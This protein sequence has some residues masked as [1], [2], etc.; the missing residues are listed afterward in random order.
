ML[1]LPNVTLVA[2]SSIL[3]DETIQALVNSMNGI[4]YYDTI[5]ITHE[6]PNNLPDS[7]RFE[8]C[9]ILS[10]INDYNKFILFDLTS[11]IKS[12]Y[13]ILVQYDGYVLRP[14][15]WTDIFF[16]YDYIGA[17]WV[18]NAHYNN[19]VNIR[20][21]NGGFTLRSKKLLDV[22]NILK[23]P[24][25]DNGTGYYSEDGVICNYYRK[26]LED[27]GIKFATPEIAAMFSHESNCDED[28]KEPFGFHK[29]KI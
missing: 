17:P 10:N 14:N 27:Y 19:G 21:G 11:F 3:I 29:Y 26:D 1:K 16:E 8:K 5:L 4:E 23:L 22:L 25:T 20:V 18:K 28:V 24:L 13:I 2:V 7:I 6:K 9:D 15:K 12:D